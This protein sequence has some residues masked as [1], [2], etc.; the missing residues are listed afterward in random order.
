MMIHLPRL[1]P[2]SRDSRTL[3]P[4]LVRSLQ[5]LHDLQEAFMHP[6]YLPLP[7]RPQAPLYTMT[8]PENTHLRRHRHLCC[9]SCRTFHSYKFLWNPRAR[10]CLCE[11]RSSLTALWVQMSRTVLP[12][13][14]HNR[15]VACTLPTDPTYLFHVHVR[16][17]IRRGAVRQRRLPRAP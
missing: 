6:H 14:V 2:H 10:S 1:R 17:S 3:P 15:Q 5:A 12:I 16:L 13:S 11:C 4:S 8:C 9:P 7:C